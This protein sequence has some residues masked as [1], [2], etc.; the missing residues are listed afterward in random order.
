MKKYLTYYEH[1]HRDSLF[2]T[3]ASENAEI[4]ITPWKQKLRG[5][6][7][8]FKY[9][10]FFAVIFSVQFT[11]FLSALI[12]VSNNM[13]ADFDLHWTVACSVLNLFFLIDVLL[14]LI[15]FGVKA[16][17]K[18]WEYF[19]EVILQ[20]LAWVFSI[21]FLISQIEGSTKT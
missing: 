7:K 15:C 21:L 16:T 6:I 18:Q 8:S 2:S 11:L 14:N 9:E 13:I 10:V 20:S 1:A 17:F 4:E 3:L 5:H 12:M 19:V